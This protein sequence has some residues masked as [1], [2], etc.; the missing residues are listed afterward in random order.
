MVRQDNLKFSGFV[1][2]GILS[3]LLTAMPA[4]AQ[5]SIS[6][7]K[8]KFSSVY[9]DT[10]KDCRGEEPLFTCKGY[11]G[12]Q[13]KIGIG[14]VFADARVESLKSE[15]GLPIAD[16]QSIAWNPVIEWRMANG[17][18][19][20]LIVRTE[21]NDPD[22]DI[23][24]KIGEQLAVI[25][26]PGFEEIGETIDAK[27]PK[28]NEKARELA[29]KGFLA[30]E[31]ARTERSA[32]AAY[33]D[34]ISAQLVAAQLADLKKLNAAIAVPTYVPAGYK[35]KSVEIQPAEAHIVAF[36]INYA[37]AGG[38]AFQIQSNNEALGDMAVKRE[39]KGRNRYFLD[40]AQE[41]ADFF[42]G[43]DAND[44]GTVASEW[45]CNPKKYQPTTTEYAQCFQLLSNA[46]SISP[47]EALKIMESLRYLKR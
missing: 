30:N 7:S 38:K 47:A 18:P 2:S 31:S 6:G 33:T 29:D 37:D 39:V 17:K 10:Q 13:I 3:L 43:H 34:G 24:K 36:S 28:A 40:S 12:Y 46:Q 32:A 4:A 14:G 1:L 21:V 25:G 41:T 19:F 44:A 27:E 11:G 8:T 16:R 26:L 9:T 35:I 23:P 22:A 5:K 20:A 15:D 42:T 45:L